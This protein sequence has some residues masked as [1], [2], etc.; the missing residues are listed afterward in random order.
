MAGNGAA[1]STASWPRA[2]AAGS[3]DRRSA[4]DPCAAVPDVDHDA[5]D[6]GGSPGWIQGVT[7]AGVE[8]DAAVGVNG[9]T[10]LAISRTVDGGTSPTAVTT[11]PWMLVE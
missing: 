8:A 6:D 4:F 1:P 5:R 9:A 3:L 7:D 11:W 10:E 2:E